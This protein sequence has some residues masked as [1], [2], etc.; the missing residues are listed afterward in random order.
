MFKKTKIP[1]VIFLIIIGIILGPL[2]SL[3]SKE[4]FGTEARIF[5]TFTLLFLLFQGALN[6]EFRN[7]FRSLKGTLKLTL[8]SFILTAGIVSLISFYGF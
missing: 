3:V 4:S 2:L 5:T 6:I 7:L 1:D 8:I